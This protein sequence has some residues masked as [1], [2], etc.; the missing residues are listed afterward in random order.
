MRD[1]DSENPIRSPADHRTRPT[2]ETCVPQLNIPYTTALIHTLTSFVAVDPDVL[3][4][5]NPPATVLTGSRRLA[6]ELLAQD[7][8]ERLAQRRKVW[9]SPD[10]LP[11]STWLERSWRECLWAGE[12]RVLLNPNQEHLLWERI[13]RE[14]AAGERLWRPRA[15]AKAAREAWT[16][17]HRWRLELPAGEEGLSEDVRVFREWAGRYRQLCEDSGWLDEASL[18]DV[19]AEQFRNGRQPAPSVLVLIGCEELSPQDRRL[20]QT[21]EGRGSKVH[22][23]ASPVRGRRAVRAGLSDTRAEIFAAARWARARLER[24]TADGIGIVVPDLAALRVEIAQVFDEVLVAEALLPGVES[25]RPYHIS[26]G[27]P[28]AE[29]PPIHNALSIL[30]LA[31]EDLSYPGAAAVLRSPYLAGAETELC[32]RALLDAR[33]RD[34]AAFTVGV[35]RLCSLVK[36]AGDPQRPYGCPILA[37]RLSGFRAL[38]RSLPERRPLGRWAETWARLLAALGWPGDRPLTSTEH[39][40]LRAWG[41][42]LEALAG[43]DLVAGTLDGRGA[44]A[45][46]R[47]LAEERVFEAEAPE[48]PVQILGVLEAQG[49]AFEQLWVMGLH[50]EAWPAAP[51]PNPFLPI[52]LQR[53]HGLPHASAERELDY[54]RRSLQRLLASAPEV[55]LSHPRAEA[56]RPLRASPLITALPEVEAGALG[57]CDHIDYRRLIHASARLERLSDGRAPELGPGAPAGGGTAMLRDQAACP[58]RAFARH[59]LAAR[60]L[61]EMGPGLDAGRRG[62]LVHEALRHLWGELRDH[63]RLCSL[64]PGVLEAAVREAVAKAMEGCAARQ[65]LAPRF[66]ALE[67]E[68][69]CALV[70]G[71]LELER[72]RAPFEVCE[73]EGERVVI[74]GG[75][76]IQIRVDRT[77]RLA[78][79]REVVIDYKTGRRGGPSRWTGDRPDD[80]QLP[81]Y[82]CTGGGVPAAVACATVRRGELGWIGVARDPGLIPGIRALGET[83]ALA[84]HGDWAGLLRHWRG[85]LEELAAAFRAGAARVDPKQGL[86]TCRDCDLATLCRVH[87]THPERAS[88]DSDD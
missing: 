57:L 8:R 38:A 61:A 76:E 39:Q 83:R 52:E 86:N 26:L 4:Q 69:L 34:R 27:R 31:V 49:L 84:E 30:Q 75:L 63:A 29:V 40:A 82:A 54:A 53:K 17:L 70:G 28:L 56:D 44:H 1:Q 87:E 48:S 71:W 64:P 79:G 9:T 50:D 80:P 60:G 36:G 18:A 81:L 41:E 45:L 37:E 68:R 46:L 88:E 16:S 24:A 20:L 25:P 12:P 72:G 19:L 66:R 3:A 2:W 10:V 5:L 35:D 6:R 43:L 85:V 74:L 77:D 11:W 62:T 59:R 58:F 67:E 32:R 23:I 13:V 33:L 47:R 7:Q 65:V 14:S 21:L 15:A 78:D 42:C 22:E 55:V 51:R 73:R